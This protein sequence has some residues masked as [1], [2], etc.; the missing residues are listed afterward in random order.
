MVNSDA[1][2]EAVYALFK[3]SWSQFECAPDQ[4]DAKQ[5][6]EAAGLHS[7]TLATHQ[8]SLSR[9]AAYCK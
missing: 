7:N 9:S 4:L 1:K 6:R 2:T 5:K 3:L 8:S